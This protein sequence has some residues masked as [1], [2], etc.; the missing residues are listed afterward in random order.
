M[1]EAQQGKAPLV[2]VE[3]KTSLE[4]AV[5]QPIDQETVPEALDLAVFL[6]ANARALRRGVEKATGITPEAAR[7]IMGE[8]YYF[9]PEAKEKTWGLKLT[10]EQIPPIPFSRTTLEKARQ[11]GK[12][13]ILRPKNAP[14][15]KPL[16]MRKENELLEK[17]FAD[18]DRGK[19]LFEDEGWKETEVF[20]NQDTPTDQEFEWALAT[21]GIIPGSTNINDLEQ[22]A[23]IAQHLRKEFEGEEMPREYAEALAEFEREKQSITELFVDLDRNWEEAVRRTSELQLNQ[24]FRKNPDA[25]LHDILDIFMNT[26][27]RVNETVCAR[28]ARRSSYDYLVYVGIFDRR[29][30]FVSFSAGY[31]RPHVGVSFSRSR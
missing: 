4:A 6:E 31:A 17:R 25:E 3:V 1:P 8:R 28:T 21:K 15:G 18:E 24:L 23:L 11:R 27:E 22:T 13:L 14:D 20:F 7:E 5:A 10:P 16:S 30:A 29:G 26:G 9:G 2:P 12:I 19:V